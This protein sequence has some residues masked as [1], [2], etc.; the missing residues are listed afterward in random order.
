MVTGHTRETRTPGEPPAST[1]ERPP[2]ALVLHGDPLALRFVRR[3]LEARSWGVISAGDATRGLQLLLDQLLDLDV[4]VTSLDL[5]HRDARS[6]VH[7]VRGAGGERDLAIVVVSRG[8]AP[9]LRAELFA[10]GVDAVVDLRHGE[11]ALA[12]A[13]L[14]VVAARRTMG[15][16]VGLA[17]G[18]FAA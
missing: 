3:S 6:L 9:E 5:P 1:P 11:A 7:L 10:L 18:A 2:R 15:R 17:G 13:V 14:R 16:A 8:A 4:L 12:E